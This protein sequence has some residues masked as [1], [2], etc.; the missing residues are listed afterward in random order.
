M[1]EALL[2]IN[3]SI[4]EFRFVAKR[5]RVYEVPFLLP[6]LLDSQLRK[7][8]GKQSSLNYLG[9]LLHISLG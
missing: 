5:L 3:P 6:K 8:W 1:M 2:L 7:N 4:Y 9:L